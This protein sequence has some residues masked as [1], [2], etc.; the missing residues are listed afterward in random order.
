MTVEATSDMFYG[1][2]NHHHKRVTIHLGDCRGCN[3]EDG[4][5]STGPTRNGSWTRG[6]VTLAEARAAVAGLEPTVRPCEICRPW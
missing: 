6:F 4:K 5:R 2:G 1:Y 3:H